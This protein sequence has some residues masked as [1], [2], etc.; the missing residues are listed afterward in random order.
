MFYIN[1]DLEKAIIGRLEFG[2]DTKLVI[3]ARKKGENR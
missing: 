2:F 1:H 3:M